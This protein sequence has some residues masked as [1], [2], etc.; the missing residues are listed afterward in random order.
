MSYTRIAKM[1]AAGILPGN[2]ASA[3]GVSPGRISQILKEEEFK[4]ILAVEEALIEKESN[5][6]KVITTK[7][8]TVEQ[9]LL[10]R[11]LE[12]APT[13]EMREATAALRV[14][15]DRQ[16]KMKQ[17]INPVPLPSSNIYNTVV[18][19]NLPKHAIPEL[20]LSSNREVIAIGEQALAPLN[21][22]GVT[23]LFKSMS[24]LVSESNEHITEGT[25]RKVHEQSSIGDKEIIQQ[26]K[27]AVR[28]IFSALDSET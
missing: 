23:D 20:Q 6:D 22:K 18:Q 28:Q 4:K 14:V 1:M 3:V 27:E 16:E 2:I 11:I 5:D 15:G 12:L 17:R 19:L 25:Y 9:S 13:S 26:Q 10:N 24:P 8:E 7:Y 21:S